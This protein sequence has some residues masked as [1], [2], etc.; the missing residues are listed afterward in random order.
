MKYIDKTKLHA[1]VSYDAELKAAHLDETSILHGAH[2]GRSGDDLFNNEIKKLP[3]YQ[4]MRTQLLE[5][6]GGVCCY[7]NRRITGHGDI[8]EHVKPKSSYRE[9]V[10]EYKNLLL[11]CE[12]GQKIPSTVP[13]GL[14][15]FRRRLY[16][17]HCDQKKGNAVLLISPLSTMCEWKVKYDPLTGKVYGDSDVSDMVGKLNLNHPVLMK[18]REE[19]IKIWCYDNSGNVLSNSQLEKVFCKMLTRDPSGYYHNLY[20][21]IASAALELVR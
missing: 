14:P 2:A 15:K 17:L 6:Q 3:S 7:C 20:Y 11:S 13:A 5:D 9:L 21:V 16:P 4:A 19:E 8:T 18:E 12:G 1:P 10:G